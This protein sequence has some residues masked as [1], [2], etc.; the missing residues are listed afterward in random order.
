MSSFPFSNLIISDAGL[1]IVE[2]RSL[3]EGVVF[4]HW[5]FLNDRPPT[6]FRLKYS[7]IKSLASP[8][9]LEFTVL[10]EDCYGNVLKKKMGLA[11]IHQFDPSNPGSP[12]VVPEMPG[13]ET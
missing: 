11:E 1:R 10:A 12:E 7:E 6:S 5:E 2:L 9:M 4:H 3:P 13:I 8:T